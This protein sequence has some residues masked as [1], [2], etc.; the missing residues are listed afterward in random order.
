VL[1]KLSLQMASASRRGGATAQAT[2]TPRTRN[3]PHPIRGLSADHFVRTVRGQCN[4]VGSN[5][6]VRAVVVSAS[7][8][9]RRPLRLCRRDGGGMCADETVAECLHAT[10]VAVCMQWLLY[11]WRLLDMRWL[12]SACVCVRATVVM[13]C[14]CRQPWPQSVCVWMMAAAAEAAEGVGAAAEQQQR[15]RRQRS[16]ICGCWRWC[17]PALPCTCAG[18]VGM[19]SAVTERWCCN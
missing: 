19:P 17:M 5:V 8:Q 10:A 6:F 1:K 7:V 11:V 9:T 4:R 16:G 14:A 13:E 18:A 3:D 12:S 2:A 15:Q